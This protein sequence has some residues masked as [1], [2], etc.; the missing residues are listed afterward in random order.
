MWIGRRLDGT[1]YGAWTVEQKSD[2][3]HP[4]L[5]NVDDNHPDVLGFK[6]R[7]RKKPVDEITPLKER[8]ALLEAENLTLKADIALMQTE[9]TTAKQRLVALEAKVT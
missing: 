1:V 5:E 7:T 2:N 9:I 8:A 6:N 3:F 4:R